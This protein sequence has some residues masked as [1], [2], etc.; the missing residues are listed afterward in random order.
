MNDDTFYKGV[1]M[2]K[3]L[4]DMRNPK[5]TMSIKVLQKE[6]SLANLAKN[7]YDVVKLLYFIKVKTDLINHMGKACDNFVINA[8]NYLVHVPN[9]NFVHQFHSKKL[10]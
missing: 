9:T 5:I 8:F 6:I 4:T 10:K 1:M 2:F 3:I 7:G